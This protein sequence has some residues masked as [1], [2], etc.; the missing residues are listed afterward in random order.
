MTDDELERDAAAVTADL[1]LLREV[2]ERS[3]GGA[4]V[5]PAS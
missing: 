5:S 4:P 3:A 2:L 1:A